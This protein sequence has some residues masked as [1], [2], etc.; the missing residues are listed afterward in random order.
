MAKT[1]SMPG[2]SANGVLRAPMCMFVRS[3]RRSPRNQPA[4]RGGRRFGLHGGGRWQGLSRLRPGM[5][6][7]GAEAQLL[8]RSVWR[9]SGMTFFVTDPGRLDQ[10][11]RERAFDRLCRH[12]ADQLL[13]FEF[14]GIVS[15][16]VV[17]EPALATHGDR[18]LPASLLHE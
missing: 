9:P 6:S 17:V 4:P 10:V 15:F 13:E 5:T 1:M 14:E 7:V 8:R 2:T 18:E 16:Y 11:H 12:L 3:P